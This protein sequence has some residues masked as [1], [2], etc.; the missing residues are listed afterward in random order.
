[1]GNN[2]RFLKIMK[3]TMSIAVLALLGEV[4]AI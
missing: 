1:M 3:V 4:S 2:Y